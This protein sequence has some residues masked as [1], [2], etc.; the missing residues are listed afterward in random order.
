[1]EK[2]KFSDIILKDTHKGIPKGRV[3]EIGK[4]LYK[5]LG[6]H[7]YKGKEHVYAQRLLRKTMKP[8]PKQPI[9]EVFNF[10]D[11]LQQKIKLPLK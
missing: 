11:T 6:F 4:K 7:L 3:F 2:M 5:I 9:F 8:S 1:M 10:K